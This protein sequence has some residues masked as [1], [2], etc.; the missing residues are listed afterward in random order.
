MPKTVLA[1]S[2]KEQDTASQVDALGEFESLAQVG[3][4]ADPAAGETDAV[5]TAEAQLEPWTAVAFQHP[6]A[7]TKD[8]DLKLLSTT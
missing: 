8:T 4:F 3:K 7:A 2:Q 5:A 6:P 1:A